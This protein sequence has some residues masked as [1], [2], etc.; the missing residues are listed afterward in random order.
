MPKRAQHLAAV[1]LLPLVAG[2]IGAAPPALRYEVP[3]LQW[4]DAPAP[5][6]PAPGANQTPAGLG[7]LLGDTRLARM[8]ETAIAHN[9]EIGIAAARVERARAELIGLRGQSLPELSAEAG[10]GREFRRASGQSLDFRTGT[11][12]LDASWEPDLFGHIRASSRAGMARAQ[13]AEWERRAMEQAI[14]GQVARAWVQRATL[15]RRLQIQDEVIARSEE[16]ER[17]VRV[18]HAAGAAT[19]VELGLQT[20]RLLEQRQRRKELEQSLDQTRT[21]LAL[22]TGALRPGFGVEDPLPTDLSLPDIQPPAPR[23][24]LVQRPDVLAAEARIQAADGDAGAARAVF[25]PRLDLSLSATVEALA[26]RPTGQLLSL[27]SSLLAP[28]FARGRLRRDLAVARADQLEAAEDYRR[29][30]LGALG[31]IEDL[32]RA[33]TLSHERSLIIEKI[34]AEARLTAR[35]GKAQYLE[36]EEDLRT[37]IDAEELLSEAE[38]AQVLAWQER[39]LTQIALH[40]AIGGNALR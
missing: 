37:L 18:R 8:I 20:I 29:I 23:Q 36:G 16:L 13:A 26:G 24:V 5:A 9:P 17:I 38:D 25:F 2:C 12:R 6:S 3:D 19:R 7:L 34:A 35:L 31:E 33:R 15:T 1:C 39:M 11:A 4:S 27:G 30:I 21:T 14:A 22:L 40:Q 28:I 10:I 32:L